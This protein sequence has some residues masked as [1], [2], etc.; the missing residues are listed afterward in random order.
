ML[1]VVTQKRDSSS[2]S[3]GDAQYA[4]KYRQ[5]PSPRPT[6]MKLDH[7]LSSRPKPSVVYRSVSRAIPSARYALPLAPTKVPLSTPYPT[8]EVGA[9]TPQ[10]M[11]NRKT[12]LV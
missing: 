8:C 11:P 12:A 10:T 7:R 1:A 3:A 9:N 5:L 6:S 2:D 4:Q